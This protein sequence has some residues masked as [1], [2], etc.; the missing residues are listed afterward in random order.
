[1]R[2]WTRRDALWLG[3]GVLTSGCGY[4]LAGRG[5]ALPANIVAI[6]VPPFVNE[7]T[8]PDVDRVLTEEPLRRRL[9]EAGRRRGLDFGVDRM[10]PLFEDAL[11]GVA[12]GRTEGR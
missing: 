12:R 8:T 4:A 2:T 7:S 5:N 6:G 9:A 3:A 10:V 1:M 11:E